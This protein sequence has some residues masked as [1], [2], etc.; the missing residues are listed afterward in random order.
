[1]AAYRITYEWAI[2]Q[3]GWSESFHT[4]LTNIASINALIT[5]FTQARV[6]F[7][8]SQAVL[9]NVRVSDDTLFRDIGTRPVL[10]G[11]IGSVSGRAAVPDAT[12]VFLMS[13]GALYKRYMYCRGLPATYCDQRQFNGAAAYFPAILA[14]ANFLKSNN[15][16]IYAQ[17]NPGTA[18]IVTGYANPPGMFAVAADIVGLAVGTYITIT[19]PRGTSIPRGK[20]RVVATP[21]LKHFQLHGWPLTTDPTAL[22]Y[23]RSSTK[24]LQAVDGAQVNDI[25]ERK[26]GRP[27]G[28]RRGR[29]RAR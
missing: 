29:A 1:M 22:A 23:V 19:A 24:A 25:G 13:S 10:G 12:V 5:A 16:A 21:D 7:L 9:L 11:Q 18:Q 26:V 20:F 27:F 4:T 14:F 17:S 15:I 8:T 6:Q 28:L 2:Q 3:S